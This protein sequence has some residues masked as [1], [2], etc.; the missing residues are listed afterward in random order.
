MSAPPSSSRR[1]RGRGRARALSVIA[2]LLA[3]APSATVV[4]PAVALPAA[5]LVSAVTA[6]PAAAATY[7]WR[8]CANSA[9]VG[10]A[11]ARD[12]VG[13]TTDGRPTQYS[14]GG[15]G[16]Y[17]TACY[18]NNNNSTTPDNKYTAWGTVYAPAGASIASATINA[19]GGN[20]SYNQAW[21][22]LLTTNSEGYSC[23]YYENQW[24]G[25]IC[26][27]RGAGGFDTQ[28]TRTIGPFAAGGSSTM[29]YGIFCRGN[30]CGLGTLDMTV[31]SLTVDVRDET[32][33]ELGVGGAA[34]SS[35]TLT[36]LPALDYSS[37]DSAVGGK[38]VVVQ[39]DGITVA[40]TRSA[41]AAGC[42]YDT[43]HPCPDDARSVALSLAGVPEGSR[44][45][46]V[47]AYDQLDNTSVPKT[48]AVIVDNKPPVLSGS[49]AL[50]GKA[51]QGEQLTCVAPGVDGQTPTLSYAWYRSR[52]DGSG[53]T[54][55]TGQTESRYLQ[56]S[57]DIGAKL[58]CLFKA[59]DAGGTS[60]SE[61]SLTAGPFADGATVAPGKGPQPTGVTKLISSGNNLAQPRVGETLTIDPPNFTGNPTIE[62]TWQRCDGSGQS[63][64]Q[65]QGA[66]GKVYALTSADNGHRIVGQVVA[67]DNT[68]ATTS[69]SEPSG[70][71]TPG[72]STST[73][74]TADPGSTPAR[75]K[76][77]ADGKDGGSVVQQIA[78]APGAANG[79]GACRD[80]K[81]AVRFPSG[82]R[83]NVR[84]GKSATL[85][86]TLSCRGEPIKGAKIALL[87]RRVGTSGEFLGAGVITTDKN[88]QFTRVIAKG[89]GRALRLAYTAFGGDAEYAA[90]ADA[91]MYVY[92]RITLKRVI[93]RATRGTRI[94]F[95]GKVQG[96][97]IPKGF[98]LDLE[99]Q[100]GRKWTALRGI[101]VRANGTFKLVFRCRCEKPG[102]LYN[103][104]VKIPKGT[105]LPFLPAASRA[106]YVR[107]R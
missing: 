75:P 15:T 36:G 5:L 83:T 31:R 66:S 49:T 3:A 98:R 43:W 56:T 27:A 50:T 44:T 85:R 10:S 93:S 71:V 82:T 48:R 78:L 104:R 34:W 12:H 102:V 26:D 39:L 28:T 57:A 62:Y 45:M 96:G 103:F 87:S 11:A 105:K 72:S 22:Y 19:G 59:V 4:V 70:L 41:D 38:G 77:G 32:R 81:L 46:Q 80:A 20:Y 100:D 65:I 8:I 17:A 6:A 54:L 9:E 74:P 58:S 67:T 68:G 7:P 90:K 33:P 86:G 21:G 107:V 24:P 91:T 30:G 79:A 88:G 14:A 23:S 61:S 99:A 69:R 52:A 37:S 51:E 55:I 84:Y 89:P 73:P 25:S 92:G 101:P 94:V 60:S 18:F 29:S 35:S 13:V 95:A 106:Y 42:N 63:C 47:I 16:P 76:D 53:K 97:G 64:V 2:G 1:A 40:D